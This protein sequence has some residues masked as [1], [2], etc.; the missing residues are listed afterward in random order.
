[1]KR[2]NELMNSS[3]LSSDS[4]TTM[5]D[6]SNEISLSINAKYLFSCSLHVP[7]CNSTSIQELVLT[8]QQLFSGD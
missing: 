1:M 5:D 8:F 7:I 2:K 4:L 3:I 6:C